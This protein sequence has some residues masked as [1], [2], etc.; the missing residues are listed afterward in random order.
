LPLP[1]KK[2]VYK[3]GLAL[4]AISLLINNKEGKGLKQFINKED[5]P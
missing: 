4:D 5:K 1:L 2:D 3:L